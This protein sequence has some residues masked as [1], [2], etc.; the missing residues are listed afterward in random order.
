MI[1]NK[2]MQRENPGTALDSLFEKKKINSLDIARAARSLE[3]PVD[4]ATLYH[5]LLMLPERGIINLGGTLSRKNI[6]CGIREGLEERYIECMDREKREREEDKKRALIDERTGLSKERH[7][8][9]RSIAEIERYRREVEN[10]QTNGERDCL[11]YMDLDNFKSI[12]DRYSHDSGHHILKKV[13][14]ALK[15][16]RRP[17]NIGRLGG[18]EFG[19]YLV[20]VSWRDIDGLASR[21]S[22]E[23]KE[24]INEGLR[25]EEIADID[26]GLSMGLAVYDP[27]PEDVDSGHNGEKLRQEYRDLER[28]A[29]DAMYFSKSNGIDY[30]IFSQEMRERGEYG[31]AREENH[32][33]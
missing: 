29:E 7:F 18:D 16:T 15:K 13:A 1:K 9:E 11:I 3:D 26:V 14:E 24:A 8:N 20:N 21:I 22:N 5:K 17:D 10:G 32:R 27:L 28:R 6:P 2:K 31:R 25:D 19:V 12:N 4:R 33:E 23:I 30:H